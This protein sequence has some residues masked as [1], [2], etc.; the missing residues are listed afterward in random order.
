[1]LNKNLNLD[2]VTPSLRY[3][4]ILL[5]YESS[6]ST[7]QNFQLLVI[8]THLFVSVPFMIYSL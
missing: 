3:L 8:Y 4:G 2:S 7:M 6:S 1:M 5:I